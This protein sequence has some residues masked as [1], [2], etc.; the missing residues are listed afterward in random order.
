MSS[1]RQR[2]TC[3]ELTSFYL[4]F[5]FLFLTIYEFKI[6]MSQKSK[7]HISVRIPR[8]PQKIALYFGMF[9]SLS[10][11]EKMLTNRLLCIL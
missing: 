8:S 4:L 1:L 9:L 7:L 2:L 10:S 6:Y 11:L 5:S 3:D